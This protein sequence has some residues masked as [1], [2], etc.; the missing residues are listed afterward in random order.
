MPLSVALLLSSFV[1]AIENWIKGLQT[2]SVAFVLGGYL[3][4]LLV[5][6]N[7]LY[8]AII[9][10]VS[11]NAAALYVVWPLL[12]VTGRF[13]GG[14]P[15]YPIWCWTLSAIVI[16]AGVFILR[17]EFRLAPPVTVFQN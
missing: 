8:A 14:L 12:A 6:S 13:S 11:I 9:A 7:S 10:H 4:W 2:M 5:R 17:R 3:G 1:F 15:D 16:V